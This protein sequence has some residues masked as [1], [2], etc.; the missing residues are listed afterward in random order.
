MENNIPKEWI[1]CKLCD[2][3]KWG[4]GGTPKSDIQEY[5]NGASASY[6]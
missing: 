5:Y 4:S 3:A 6:I 1:E 2:I